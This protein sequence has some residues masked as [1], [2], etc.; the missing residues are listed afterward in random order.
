VR[1]IVMHH[2]SSSDTEPAFSPVYGEGSWWTHAALWLGG[3]LM[4]RGNQLR[5]WAERHMKVE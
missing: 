1:R 5:Y 3:Q 2:Y 4:F